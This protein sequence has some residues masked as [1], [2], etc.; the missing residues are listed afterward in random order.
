MSWLPTAARFDAAVRKEVR[1]PDFDTLTAEV[2]K[3]MQDSKQGMSGPLRQSDLLRWI[4]SGWVV[5]VVA[6][7][8][9]AA[10]AAA[11][12]SPNA[13]G[14]QP[15]KVIATVGA[16]LTFGLTYIQWRLGKSEATFDKHYERLRAANDNLDKFWSTVHVA[17]P[18]LLL[19]HR[20]NMLVFSELD[21]LEY[22]IGKYNALYAD[23]LTLR[24][25]VRH[26]WSMCNDPYDPE[27]REAVLRWIGKDEAS[28]DAHGYLP[29]TCA[30]ARYLA[31][32]AHR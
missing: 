28:R 22:V 11:A 12:L 31:E 4:A 17:S 10:Y 29:V 16:A 14:E 26:F 32:V 24:R 15:L 23:R 20:R 5:G 1:L 2:V 18:G 13:F 30:I 9:V 27:R 7:A 25:A 21:N 19:D 6:L 8:S 3:R